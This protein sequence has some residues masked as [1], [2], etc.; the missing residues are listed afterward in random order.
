MSVRA[1][2]ALTACAP[3]YE[4]LWTASCSRRIAGRSVRRS[5]REQHQSRGVSAVERKLD[6]FL[7]TD[8][9]AESARLCLHHFR[10]GLDR[11]GL[12]G[13]TDLQAEGNGRRLIG[14]TSMP[15]CS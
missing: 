7:L 12:A 15:R 10:V 2:F 13:A 8:Y 3:G 4:V 6:D 5:G 1:P 9:L 11:Y 14:P